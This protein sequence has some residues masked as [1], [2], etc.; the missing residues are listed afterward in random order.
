MS[1]DF[2][3]SDPQPN[4][5]ELE[6]SIEQWGHQAL[7]DEEHTAIVYGAVLVELRDPN[8][9]TRT[10][11]ASG[12]SLEFIARIA[13]TMVSIEQTDRNYGGAPAVAKAVVRIMPPDILDSL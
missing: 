4:D 12:V 1:N 6:A 8:S 10:A 9:V 11:L 7:A 2:I 5:N 13:S 3:Y